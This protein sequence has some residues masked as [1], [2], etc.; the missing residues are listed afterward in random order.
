MSLNCCPN[1]V[2]SFWII[3]SLHCIVQD[4]PLVHLYQSRTMARPLL[5]DLCVVI[6]ELDGEG[7]VPEVASW[8]GEGRLNT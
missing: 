1:L 7:A 3:F 6:G 5:T 8:G 2:Y 4:P